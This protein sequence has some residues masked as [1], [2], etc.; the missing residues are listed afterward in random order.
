MIGFIS[1]VCKTARLA[2]V[3][4]KPDNPSIV[5]RYLPS[6]MCIF[7]HSCYLL[8]LIVCL[9]YW[10]ITTLELC[11]GTST[12]NCFVDACGKHLCGF[13]QGF[14]WFYSLLCERCL[15]SEA[16]FCHRPTNFFVFEHLV[17]LYLPQ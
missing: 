14:L 3:I 9:Q 17:Q 1:V 10:S 5:V 16:M 13:G 15:C 12:S 7:S 6:V 8:S 4:N 11:M 2:A